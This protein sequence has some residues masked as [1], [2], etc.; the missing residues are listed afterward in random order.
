V[1]SWSTL[2]STVPVYSF[3]PSPRYIVSI[4]V[5]AS[6]ALAPLVVVLLEQWN[7]IQ[8]VVSPLFDYKIY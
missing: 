6:Y 7:V 3:P 5:A 2:A 1:D 4:L 8:F